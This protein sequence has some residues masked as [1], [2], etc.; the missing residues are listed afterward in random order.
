MSKDPLGDRMKAYEDI[1]RIK[2]PRRA[3][4]IV[5]LDGRAFSLLT[6]GMERPFDRAFAHA[7][8]LT[9]ER[10]C[11][12]IQGAVLAYTQS[13]EISLLL[14]DFESTSTQPWFDGNLQKIV[15][16][17]AGMASVHFHTVL[18]STGAIMGHT[19]DARAFSLSDPVEVANYFVWR[20]RDAVRNSIQMA[21]QAKFSQSQLFGK[22][23]NEIQEMLFQE[24]QINWNDYPDGFK[25]GR[26]CW[27]VRHDLVV[28]EYG[29]TER[30]RWTTVPAPH[31][32]AE[33]G[34]FLAGLIP[35]MPTL[36]AIKET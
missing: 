33:S 6:R 17:S 24:H 12:E 27:K 23:T 32:V 21:G 7:M 16:I 8:Y 13:D 4:T 22:S 9:A 10:L 29:T 35:P 19:F 30:Y 14:Q 3:Y 25:R 11:G 2:L 31:F 20:Q 15:S 36:S 26:V 18:D 1:W 28:P 34:T 5:R